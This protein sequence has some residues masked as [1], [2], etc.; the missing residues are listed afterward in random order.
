MMI[1][2][3]DEDRDW[4]IQGWVFDEIVGSVPT[5]MLRDDDVDEHLRP[6][7]AMGLLDLQAREPDRA[8]RIITALSAGV[9]GRMRTLDQSNDKYVEFYEG[10]LRT[11]AAAA[12]ELPTGHNGAHSSS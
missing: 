1:V 6:G 9:V 12:R 3:F 2:A 11:A 8:R 10:L 5:G 7:R 4:Y